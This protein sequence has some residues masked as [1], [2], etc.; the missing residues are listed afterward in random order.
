[1]GIMDIFHASK[2]KKE[3][4]RLLT[5]LEDAKKLLT[6]EM[7]D[8]C[9]LE[10]HIRELQGK[11][12][13]INESINKANADLDEIKSKI[14]T[15]QKMLVDVEEQLLYQD[16]ALYKPKY[17][18][19]N[20]EAY[21]ERLNK[22]RETQKALIKNVQAVTGN[23]NWTVNGSKS[24]GKKMV[25]DMQ[26][27]L[28]RAFNSECDE[29][30]SRVTY[31][32]IEL[33]EKRLHTSFEAISKLGRIMSV[34]ITNQYLKAKIEELYLA[35]EYKQKKQEEKEEQKELRAQ[36]REEAKLQKEI[37]EARKKI[38]KEQKHYQNALD[39]I[40]KQL[41]TATDE[42]KADLEQKKAVIEAQLGE[43]DKNIKDIDYRESNA[44]AGYVYI[45]SNIG[46]FGENVYK[47]G[48]TRRLDP[49]ER[50]DE[51]SDASVPFNFDIHAM[52]F[53]DN[54]PALEAALH[55]AFES[56]KLN[57]VNQRREFF[58]VTLDEIKAVVMKNFDKSVEFIEVPEAEQYR[59]SLKMKEKTHN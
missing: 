54:A 3:N 41:L 22:I 37:E 42:Q 50:I 39:S 29:V 13:A 8:A 56:K 9:N 10:N 33:S 2:I 30:I 21:K 43:I 16:F 59:T 55:K 25:K 36:L 45:I 19:V 40:N 57:M 32:N 58:N 48:M 38:Q 4:E 44:K 46:A 28:L 14:D 27:L 26:K 6:P 1:M 20:S 31:A 5:E 23:M 24:E 12:N 53:S 47:I 18:M 11:E 17:E 15:K 35:F 34:A 52:I 51:L 49:Q 7:M